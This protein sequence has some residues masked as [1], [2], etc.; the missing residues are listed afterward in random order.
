V[1]VRNL[2]V[3]FIGL[4]LFFSCKKEQNTPLKP[5][6]KDTNTNLSQLEIYGLGEDQTAGKSLNKSYNFYFDQFDGSKFQSI[7]CGPTVTT[8]AIKWADSTFSRKP[9]DARNSIPE[10][11]GWWYTSD[12]NNYLS[13]NDIDHSTVQFTS[14][15]ADQVIENGI[16]NN[17]VIILCLDMYYAQYNP[18]GTQHTNKF[19]ETAAAGWGHFLLVKG[20]KTVDDKTYYEI[21][22]PYSDHD[23]Y[24]NDVLKGKDRYYLNSDITAATDVWWKYAIV[25]APKGQKVAA[26]VRQQLNSI[27]NIPVAKGQ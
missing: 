16:N 21:Y 5:S 17:N 3:V 13:A 12:I 14:T 1:K 7:N 18:V 22:D 27:Q 11:G 19:Y 23:T 25:V 10:S 20:F 26:S 8:M 9:V 15:N 6:P 24:A 2:P 4:L